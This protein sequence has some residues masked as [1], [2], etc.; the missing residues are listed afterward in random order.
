MYLER[1]KSNRSK[2][3]TCKGDIFIDDLRVVREDYS[4][5]QMTKKFQCYLC[6]LNNVKGE[7][8]Q[9]RQIEYRLL[10]F[11]KEKGKQE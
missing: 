3:I 10:R 2:C 7:L 4:F 5:G 1:A 6:A 9:L 8:Q 11:I